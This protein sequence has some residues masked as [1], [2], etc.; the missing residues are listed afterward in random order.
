MVSPIHDEVA[1]RLARLDQRYTKLRRA[2]VES[3]S[4]EVRRRL[5]ALIERLSGPVSTPTELRRIRAIGVL[6]RLGTADA[7]ALLAELA[8]GPVHPQEAR[9][10]RAALDRLR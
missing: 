1:L 4:A 10:A 7:P 8:D 5:E 3:N 6:E 2:L 9:T